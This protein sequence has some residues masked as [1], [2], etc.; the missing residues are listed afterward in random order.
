MYVCSKIVK[1]CLTK[2]EVY[3]IIDLDFLE[4]GVICTKKI[5]DLVG[6]VSL[7]K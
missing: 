5:E 7:L 1:K 2:V 4:G 6:L 3:A